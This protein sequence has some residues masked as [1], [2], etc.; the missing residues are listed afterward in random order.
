MFYLAHIFGL[1]NELSYSPQG[2]KQISDRE[3]IRLQKE[4]ILM[5]KE[6]KKQ[7]FGY[8]FTVDSKIG[9]QETNK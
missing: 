8:V 3:G 6:S 5:E 1:L 2:K 7:E 4:V 9:D